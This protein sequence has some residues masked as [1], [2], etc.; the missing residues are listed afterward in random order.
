[1]HGETMKLLKGILKTLPPLDSCK[2]VCSWEVEINKT[3]LINL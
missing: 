3:A 1:M 2:A